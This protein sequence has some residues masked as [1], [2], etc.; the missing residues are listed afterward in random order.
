MSCLKKITINPKN[1]DN[2]RNVVEKRGESNN[3][4]KNTYPR[5][6]NT[7]KGEITFIIRIM[8]QENYCHAY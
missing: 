3:N 4:E 1:V 5:K 6:L 7:E 8:Q 2:M